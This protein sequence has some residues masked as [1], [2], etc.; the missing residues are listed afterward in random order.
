MK[1]HR[2]VFLACFVLVAFGLVLTVSCQRANE[3]SAERLAERALERASGGTAKVDLSK[4]GFKIKTKEG[5]A[6]IGALTKWPED[7]PAEVPKFEA[8]TFKSASKSSANNTRSWIINIHDVTESDV[9]AYIEV[10]KAA[11]WTQAASSTTE[12]LVIF[13]AEK[14]KGQLH[15]TYS[16]REKGLALGIIVKD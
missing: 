13:M 4:G 6:E 11:G 8:G 1:S 2:F 7:V 16:K 3:R 14:D 15:V 12:D 5:E 10:V 9:S